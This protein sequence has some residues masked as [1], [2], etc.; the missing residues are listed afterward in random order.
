MLIDLAG[1]ARLAGVRRA[2]PSVWRT[3]FRDGIDAFPHVEVEKNGRPFFDAEAVAHWLVRT[4]HGNNS[5]PVV[6]IGAQGAPVDFDIADTRH[7]SSVDALL[8]LHAMLDEPLSAVDPARLDE[9]A[10]ALDPQDEF[11]YSEVAR[12]EPSWAGWAE[13]LADAEYSPLA[14]SRL[15]ERRHDARRGAAGSGGPLSGQTEALLVDLCEALAVP[16]R[17]TLSLSAGWSPALALQLI[18]R[19][20]DPDLVL[21][22]HFDGR[23]IRRRLILEGR[24]GPSTFD[25]PTVGIVHLVRPPAHR[26]TSDTL[27]IVDDLALG[28]RELDRAVVFGPAGPLLGALSSS[29]DALRSDVVRT[30]RVRAIVRLPAGLVTSAVREPLALWVLGRETG[31]VPIP[32][33]FTAIC[34]LSDVRLGDAARHD[35]VT[36]VVAAMGGRRDVR[37]HAFR[38]ARLVRTA[39]ILAAADGVIPRRRPAPTSARTAHDIPARLDRAYAALVGPVPEARPVA[40]PVPG[41]DAAT[42]G[43]IV[44]SGHA[45]VIPGTRV[46][47]EEDTTEGLVSIRAEDLDDPTTIGRRRVDQIAF[48]RRHPTARLTM[49]GDVVFRTSPTPRA[50]VDRAG[51]SVVAQPA[52]VLRVSSSDPG[53]LVPELLALDIERATGGSGAWRRWRVRRVSP[54][55][56]PAL[57]DALARIVAQ[58]DELTRRFD[59]L[60]SYADLLATGVAT[61]SVTLFDPAAAAASDAL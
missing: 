22:D 52:R 42:L 13:M 20:G 3:R 8:T 44:T 24:A 28:M 37:A 54:S 50:W 46:D 12:A 27:R 47:P 9:M 1:I 21:P 31:E 56:A 58:R 4:S 2:V 30:G 32:E 29:E 53:G 41:P 14:A 38:F 6:D 60:T 11:L 49:P 17:I 45:R 59:A 43:E 55:A 10:R 57:G 15:M 61:G 5:D 25:A 35:L 18:D 39:S 40:R 16:R 51:S 23:A 34:D 19:I 33:R 26:G 7:V 36:D 48:A